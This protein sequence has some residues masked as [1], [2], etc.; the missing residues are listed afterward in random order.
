MIT[1]LSI[2]EIVVAIVTFAFGLMETI[3][4]SLFLKKNNLDGARKQH[5]LELSADATDEQVK[6]KIIRMLIVGIIIIVFVVLGV[7]IN[8]YLIIISG[9]TIFVS[10]IIDAITAKKFIPIIEWGAFLAFIAVGVLVF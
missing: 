10:G 9:I 4:N 2:V 3:V 5:K 7:F 6:S 8:K 1:D